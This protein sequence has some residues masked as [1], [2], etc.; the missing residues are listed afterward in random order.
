[1]LIVAAFCLPDD[2]VTEIQTA[3]SAAD[4]ACSARAPEPVARRGWLSRSA[5]KP[6]AAVLPRTSIA[7]W[8]SP[9]IPIVRFG[10][11]TSADSRRVA[12][13]LMTV[14]SAWEPATV[15]VA[16]V[17]WGGVDQPGSVEANLAGDVAGLG[18]IARAVTSR[19]AD[20]NFYLD[21]RLFHAGLEVAKVSE[22]TTPEDLYA[23]TTSLEGF[24]SRPWT[25]DHLTLLRQTYEP[26]TAAYAE[27]YQ[28]PFGVG[29]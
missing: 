9:H 29:T 19:A 1:M 3:I 2:V 25:V 24:R 10:N 20:L 22:S 21:R 11:L 27:A 16:Q 6:V 17:T 23:L 18:S 4:A 14:A 7:Q 26:G 12:D 5:T 15:H 28:I 13:A 8:S